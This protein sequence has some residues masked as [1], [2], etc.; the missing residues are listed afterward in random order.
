[1]ILPSAILFLLLASAV[2]SDNLQKEIEEDVEKIKE[3]MISDVKVEPMEM[4]EYLEELKRLSAKYNG[5]PK[6]FEDTFST[7]SFDSDLDDLIDAFNITKKKCNG[8][9]YLKLRRMMRRHERRKQIVLY[10]TYL[11]EKL[12]QFCM[13]MSK[14]RSQPGYFGIGCHNDH[15]RIPGMFWI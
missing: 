3:V 10:L 7:Y 6:F 2:N 4:Y 1:M 12:G 14:A 9:S 8:Q 15:D 11:K 13:I 5:D